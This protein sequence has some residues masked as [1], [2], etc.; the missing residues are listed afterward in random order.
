MKEPSQSDMIIAVQQ[1][2][3]C[4]AYDVTLEKYDIDE[5]IW[6]SGNCF[7]LVITAVTSPSAEQNGTI[8]SFVKLFHGTM[9]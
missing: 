8:A 7:I 1:S 3:G 4:G 2:W 6:R 5:T 9:G